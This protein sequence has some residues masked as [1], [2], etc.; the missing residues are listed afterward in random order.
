MSH[1]AVVQLSYQVV[2]KSL[3]R[4]RLRSIRF[5]KR[6]YKINKPFR[7][8]RVNNKISDHKNIAIFQGLN[9][10]RFIAALLVVLHHSETIKRK[11]EMDNLEWLGLFSN[12][13]HAVT[14][15]F[16]LSGFLITY[17][18]LKER[19]R[20]GTIKVKKF[21][22]KRILRIW[23]LYFLLIFIGAILLPYLFSIIQIDYEMPYNLRQTWF[24]FLFFMPG[25]VTFYFGHHLLEPLWS[26]G[27]EE[28]FYLIWAPLFK[29]IKE[30]VWVLL[31]SV[32][33]FKIILYVLSFVIHNELL[34]FLIAIFKFESMAVGGLGSYLIYTYGRS[35]TESFL[36]KVPIQ[37]IIFSTLM[38][39]LLF[40]CNIH[41]NVWLI[42]F[43]TP[44]LSSLL[45]DF[46][47]LYAIICISTVD[48]SIIRLRSKTMSLLGEISYGIYMYHML[49]I[50][51][52]ILLL[53]KYLVQISVAWSHIAFYGIVVFCTIIVSVLSKYFFENYF[54][55]LKR[56][57]Y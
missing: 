28:V 52:A 39:F 23:P 31:L 57:Y 33:L 47:F 38:V 44:V 29:Y 25:L 16:V 43:Q 17:L 24:Y 36:F 50:F 26:I 14:F 42:V 8:K 18:L 40:H 41:N 1:P 5:A 27:V 48:N 49:I 13:G 22:L 30:R 6:G 46:L 7:K 20:V 34:S 35:F 32:I 54:L 10:L 3:N 45:I 4:N 53:K 2:R 9:A 55:Q 56:R 11:Y 37:I 19:E 51:G 15:F 21:Y 12:G